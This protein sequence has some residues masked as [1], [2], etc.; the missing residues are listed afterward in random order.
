MEIPATKNH[1]HRLV[2]IQDL[3]NP[4]KRLMNKP[5]KMKTQEEHKKINFFFIVQIH[6]EPWDCYRKRIAPSRKKQKTRTYIQREGI[7]IEKGS[8]ITIQLK[9]GYL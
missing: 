2:P 8:E 7:N 6:L 1:F 9:D 4:A 5:K 3:Q